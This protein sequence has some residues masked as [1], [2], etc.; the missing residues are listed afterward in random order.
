MELSNEQRVDLKDFLGHPG[1]QVMQ[2]WI[3]S[4]IER[5]NSIRDI[6]NA[7]LFDDNKLLYE[8]RERR[9]KIDVYAGLLN[10]MKLQATKG[11]QDGKQHT[12]G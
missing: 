5:N 9:H 8:I 2:K 3:E 4:R 1:W 6:D 10:S 12:D 11:D 7:T